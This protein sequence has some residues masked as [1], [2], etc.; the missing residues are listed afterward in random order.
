V[1]LVPQRVFALRRLTALGI[2]VGTRDRLQSESAAFDRALTHYG[3][4]HAYQTYDGDHIDGVA[5]RIEAVVMP[6]FARHL[7]VR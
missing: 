7:V 5:A 3:I 4:P 2:D 1:A 6:F